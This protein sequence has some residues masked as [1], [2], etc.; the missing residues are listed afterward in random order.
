ML[1]DGELDAVIVGNDVPDDP[2]FR[3]VFPDPKAAAEHFRA[4]H[5]FMPVNHMITVQT[6]L[7]EKRPDL[8][9]EF[10]EELH[11]SFAAAGGNRDLLIGRAALLPAINLALRFSIE[12]G[13]VP[14]SMTAEQVWKGLPA[15]I[16]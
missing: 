6:S 15:S 2:V 4:K 12:Q 16:S 3:T 8:V 13:L 11:A 5:G 14:A 9:V 10:L 7:M 1:R